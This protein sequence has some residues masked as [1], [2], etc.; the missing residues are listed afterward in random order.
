MPTYPAAVLFDMDGTLLDTEPLWATALSREAARLGGTL[1]D[2]GLAHL[3]GASMEDTACYLLRLA[4]IN[5]TRGQIEACNA[6]IRREASG[7]FDGPLPW[8]PGASEALETMRAAGIPIALVTSTERRFVA[9]SLRTLGA[10]GAVICGDEVERPKPHPEPY[11]RAA[12]LLHVDPAACLAVEDSPTG[13]SAALAAGCTVLVIPHNAPVPP[14]PGLVFAR[15]L[16]GFSLAALSA[17]WT[18]EPRAY[19]VTPTPIYDGLAR[20]YSEADAPPSPP[21]PGP[22][23]WLPPGHPTATAPLPKRVRQRA[24]GEIYKRHYGAPAARP[25]DGATSTT[26]G[27]V[28]PHPTTPALG[29]PMENAETDRN[30]LLQPE[31]G[32]LNSTKTTNT[33]FIKSYG[34]DL[35]R[36][37][38]KLRREY[39]FL[40]GLPPHVAAHFP[41]VTEYHDDKARPWIELRLERIR[42]PALAKAILR[43]VTTP[44]E[45]GAVLSSVLAFLTTDLYPLRGGE[46]S[47]LDL[48]QRYHGERMAR[49]VGLLADHPELRP[50]VTAPAVHVNGRKCPS[51][52]AILTWL[53]DHAPELFPGAHHLV[54]AHGD[55][56]LDNIML[57]QNGD[58]DPG[59][60]LIDPR[61]EPLLPPH[62]DLAKLLKALR[63]GY[64]LIHY[65]QYRFDVRLNSP[66]PTISLRIDPAF[67]DHYRAGMKVLLGA[68]PEF[69]QAEGIS[70]EAFIRALRVAEIAHVI[71][72]ASYHLHRPDGCDVARVSA[73]L[74]IAALLARD[75]M[76]EAPDLSRPLPIWEMTA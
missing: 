51:M 20:Q 14:V 12:Q 69:S 46:I 28:P 40:I 73:Y 63:A 9:R 25:A 64:D 7:L 5:P 18:G 19:A 22:R 58:D 24:L 34:G 30:R 66:V 2:A 16:V 8:R 70:E 35:P 52:R 53:D 41:T 42:H 26:T 15:S 11:L 10:F 13:S 62:Y 38:E 57:V 60:Y 31:G 67:G 1:T 61:G 68:L 32:S 6:R 43:G 50:L 71:S 27:S 29:R 36:G 44:A 74:A 49:A 37:Y 55:T 33:E 3:V 23:P 72:F 4:G 17:I 39:G 54:A 48:Y 47:G 65:G 21:P 56:H 59:F 76:I 75:L 45:V